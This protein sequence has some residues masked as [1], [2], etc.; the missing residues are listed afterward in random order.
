MSGDHRTTER[1][2]S[3]PPRPAVA[4]P[5]PA[6]ATPPVPPA[7]P[8][9][10]PGPSPFRDTPRVPRARRARLLKETGRGRRGICARP[11]TGSG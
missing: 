8:S 6:T 7:P 4:A 10:F 5:H 9:P 3:G 11:D 1:R 2:S